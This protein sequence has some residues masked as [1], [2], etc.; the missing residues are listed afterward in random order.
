MHDV[1]EQIHPR[2]VIP[3]HF[4]GPPALERFLARIDARYP[5]TRSTSAHV[6]LSQA[7]L[8]KTTEVL[9]LPGF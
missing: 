5:V 4:F 6:A 7:T 2:L 3:M 8:P 1:V 9:V